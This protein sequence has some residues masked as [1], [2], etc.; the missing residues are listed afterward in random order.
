MG[1]AQLTLFGFF[2]KKEGFLEQ[3]A[4]L[5]PKG[6]IKVCVIFYRDVLISVGGSLTEI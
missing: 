3:K 2:I 4:K 5:E 1:Y 6:S